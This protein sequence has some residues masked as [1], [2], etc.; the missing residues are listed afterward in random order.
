M[1]MRE[2]PLQNHKGTTV[3]ASAATVNVRAAR[4]HQ[5]YRI[6]LHARHLFSHLDRTK[7]PSFLH[8]GRAAA[9]QQTPLRDVPKKTAKGPQESRWWEAVRL[10]EGSREQ[11]CR[12]TS[13]RI[14]GDVR[15]KE[16]ER[17]FP[18]LGSVESL[19]VT[20]EAAPPVGQGG[21]KIVD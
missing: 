5:H 20:P 10:G 6:E 14:V 1:L 17:A 19:C 4:L 21:E 18:G 15:G 16:H 7:N 11:G 2:G 13:R 9:P 12:L 3:A 8:S